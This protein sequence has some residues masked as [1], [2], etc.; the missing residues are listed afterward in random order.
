MA[1]SRLRQPGGV[2]R[3]ARVDARGFSADLRSGRNEALMKP[4]RYPLARIGKH[5]LLPVFDQDLI[6]LLPSL[7]QG[8]S[9]TYPG[10]DQDLTRT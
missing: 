8:L 7:R 1:L 6:R 5:S 3:A 10:L 4:D 9:R 2:L